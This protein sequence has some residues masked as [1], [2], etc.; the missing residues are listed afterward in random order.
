[1]GGYTLRTHTGYT[2]WER[3]TEAR[4]IPVLPRGLGENEARSIPVLP[5][6]WKRMMRVLPPFFGRFGRMM[7]VLSPFFGRNGKNEA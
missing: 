2:P 6:V 5:W 1:M 7:R 3:D 4:S